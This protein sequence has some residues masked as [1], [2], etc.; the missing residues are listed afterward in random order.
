MTGSRVDTSTSTRNGFRGLG[1]ECSEIY[2]PGGLDLRVYGY[3]D[4]DDD[5]DDSMIH[6]RAFHYRVQPCNIAAKCAQ[7]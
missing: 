5:D 7:S 6:A 4:D 2:D 3:D 1:V